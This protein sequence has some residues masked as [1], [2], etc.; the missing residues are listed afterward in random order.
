MENANTQISH[1]LSPSERS[2]SSSSS[3]SSDKDDFM[4]DDSDDEEKKQTNSE[5]KSEASDS[6]SGDLLTRLGFGGDEESQNTRSD[7]FED[8]FDEL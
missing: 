5:S 1:D 8:D 3:S 2:E 4:R 6:G 7:G